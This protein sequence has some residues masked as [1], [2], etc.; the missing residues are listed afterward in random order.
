VPEVERELAAALG[1]KLSHDGA[2]TALGERRRR[3]A[4]H[5]KVREVA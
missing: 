2:K 5:G 1:L 4:N 3:L